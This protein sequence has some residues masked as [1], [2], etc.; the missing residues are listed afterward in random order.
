MKR[1]ALFAS[2]FL[3]ATSGQLFAAAPRGWFVAGSA[4]QFYLV[5]LDSSVTYSGS[6]STSLQAASSQPGGFV[7]L[8][9]SFVADHYR[10][11]RVRFSGY[12][13]SDG[14][15]GWAGLWMRIDEGSQW[16]AFD[17]MQDRPIQGTSDWTPYS[18]VLDVADG[19]TAVNFGILLSG[20]GTVWLS[21]VKF[22]VVDSDTP[23]TGSTANAEPS[24]LDFSQ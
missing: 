2:V 22:E 17:N 7:T 5:N 18:V 15:G 12:V 9:Q 10:E 3:L 20:S 23:L 13:K 6:P 1:K 16:A 14:V 8:M 21:G 4:P 19:A 11:K 24:N